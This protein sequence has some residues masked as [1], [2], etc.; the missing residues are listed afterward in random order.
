[1]GDRMNGKLF[2]AALAIV[3]VTMAAFALPSASG[4]S[5]DAREAELYAG[6][7]FAYSPSGDWT[8]A[9]ASGTALGAGMEW[10]NGTLS[11][12]I[13]EPGTY[14]AVFEKAD[15]S[16][17]ITLNVL[18]SLAINESKVSVQKGDSVIVSGAEEG[19][20]VFPVAVSGPDGTEVSVECDRGLFAFDADEGF[21]LA[22]DIVDSDKGTYTLTVRASHDSGPLYAEM[23]LE[24][25]VRIISQAEASG[26]DAEGIASLGSRSGS[27]TY[28]VTSTGTES[29]SNPSYAAPS[30]PAVSGLKLYSDGRDVRITSSVTDAT[31]L[32]YNWGDGIR[33]S[34]AVG[35]VLNG[36]QHTYAHGGTY[37]VVITAD[38]P[39]SSG[40][41]VAVF[42]TPGDAQKGLIEEHGLIFILFAVLAALMA[43]AFF[44]TRDARMLIA[45]AVSAVLA[46]LCFFL[47]VGA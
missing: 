16:C 45:L 37:S 1:M 19:A 40:Y 21:V 42:D 27:V 18:P 44:F 5:S 8:D 25:N 31:K 17:A 7:A 14:R 41:A 29:V 20:L 12:S 10:K 9:K 2:G 43:V 28:A 11:G 46:V 6:S 4:D 34:I 3:I 15:A 13:D 32:T 36:A 38:G 26:L 47:K 24:V 30:E 33:T 35:S 39:Y 22:R 23:S